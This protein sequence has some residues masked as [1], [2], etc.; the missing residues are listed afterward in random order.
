MRS[1]SAGA[2]LNHAVRAAQHDVVVLAHQDAYVHDPGLLQD[3]AR[4]FDDGHYGLLGPVGMASDGWVVGS[5]RD[6]ASLDRSRRTHPGRRRLPRRGRDDGPT[7]G[8]AGH[9]SPRTPSSVGMRTVSSCRPDCVEPGWRRVMRPSDHPQQPQPEHGQSRTGPRVR[10]PSPCR[11]PAS[12]HDV[13]HDRHRP[14]H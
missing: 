2:A 6:R 3:A 7:H 5:M 13:R 1:T 9:P 14:H 8:A 11:R 10:R 4:H 12:A